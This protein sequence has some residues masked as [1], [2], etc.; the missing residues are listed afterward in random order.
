MLSRAAGGR[1]AGSL[2]GGVAS[3]EQRGFRV[4]LPG[5]H[6]EAPEGLKPPRWLDRSGRGR[7]LSGSRVS[8]PGLTVTLRSPGGLSG[9]PGSAGARWRALET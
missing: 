6:L 5:K 9:L 7:L 4:S 2:P 1:G 3:S 8:A